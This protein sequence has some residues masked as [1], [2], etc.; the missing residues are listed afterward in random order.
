MR[1]E[2]HAQDPESMKLRFHTQT[3][4]ETLTA[5]QPLNNVV[6]VTLQALAAVLGGTQSLHTNS[7]DEALSLPTEEAVKLALR[8]QQIIAFE[9]G[10]TR[11]ADPL[12]GSY[13]L[14]SLTAEIEKATLDEIEKVERLG[15]AVKA[16]QKGYVQG[17]IRESAFK[18][19]ME[20]ESGT[21]KIVGL[22]VFKDAE[23]QELTIHKIDPRSVRKQIAN[24]KSF[25]RRRRKAETERSLRKLKGALIGS[26]NLVPL[27]IGAVR[28]GATTGEISDVVRE[29]YGEFHPKTII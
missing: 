16:I 26:Q 25:K 13:Y 23:Q 11:T 3:S 9:S 24:V 4:G 19:Q 27:I 10:V 17:Q 6:R 18:Q 20:V 22:N 1:N 28:A 29:A 2:F 15:G 14:E 21:R 5:Q 12:G 8:T 7:L